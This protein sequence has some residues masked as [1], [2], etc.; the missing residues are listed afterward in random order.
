MKKAYFVAVPALLAL[1]VIAGAGCGGAKKP[2]GVSGEPEVIG[3]GKHFLPPTPVVKKVDPRFPPLLPAHLVASVSG[4]TLG[5]FLARREGLSAMTAYIGGAEN[6]AR[7]LVTAPLTDAGENKGPARVIAATPSETNALVLRATGGEKAGFVAAWTA[8]TDRGEALR[9]IGIAEDGT[10]RGEP[11]EIARTTDDI[12][13]TDIVPTARGAVCVW[14]EE[15]RSGDANVL[16]VA[17]DPDGRPR[18]VPS[19]VAKGVTGWQAVP[20]TMG[21]GLVLVTRSPEKKAKGGQLSWLRL[22]GEARPIGAA[23]AVTIKPTVTGDVDVARVGGSYVFAWTDPTA[24][25]PEVSLA[26]IDE[27]GAAHAPLHPITALG[28]SSLVALSGGR[29]SG[30]IAWEEPSKRGHPTRRLHMATLSPQG[31]LDGKKSLALEVQ[32]TSPPELVPAGDGFALL[33]PAQ[34]CTKADAPGACA[35]STPLPMFVRLDGSLSVVQVE[36]LRL[37]DSAQNE[38]ASPLAAGLAWGLDC[39]AGHCVVLTATGEAPTLVHAIELKDRPSPYV[40]PLVVQP[41][42]DAPHAT[43]LSTLAA[44][45]PYADI[46]AARIGDGSLVALVTATTDDPIG[47]TKSSKARPA[48]PS[49]GPG[50]GATLSLRALDAAG[51]AHGPAVTLTTRAVSVGGVAIAGGPTP[52]DGAAVAWVAR[53]GGDPQVHVTLVDRHGKKLNDVL[54][55]TERGDASDVAITWAGAGWVV[56]WV[57][58]RDGNGEVYASHLSPDLKRIAGQERVTKALGDASDV[59]LLARDG[60]VWLAWADPRESPN[61]G[62]SDIYIAPLRAQDARRSGDEVRLLATA[63][64]SRSPSLA[65][66]GDGIVV[67]W[68]EEAPMGAEATNATAYGAMLAWVDAK[69][70][71]IGE[72][73]RTRGSGEGFPSAIILDP[74]ATPL[75]GILA[76]SSRF[77]LALDTLEVSDTRAVRTYP[78]MSLDGPPSLD[79]SLALLDNIVF[80]NDDGPEAGARRARALTLAWSR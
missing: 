10:A 37:P 67:G 17:L 22:D 56:A 6:G 52:E 58:G 70:H 19:H 13:W 34:T 26:S 30:V 79:V 51:A 39:A 16:A 50:S 65:A 20:T 71:R 29:T 12:V 2:V 44:G 31:T 77:E 41:P 49:R 76:R 1:V 42:A 9:V 33:A 68:I 28:G 46:A 61:D 36:A 47:L 73:V 11:H 59:S 4:K 23:V 15:L 57:D 69:G 60:T 32:G 48:P 45:E 53:E 55:T 72:A 78:I 35:A 8:M 24:L 63:A 62:F 3:K 74:H 7:H 27:S 75:R 40:P 25:D 21:A 66:S 64:H 38:L 54:V 5:P 43:A 14:A 80:F 18:G